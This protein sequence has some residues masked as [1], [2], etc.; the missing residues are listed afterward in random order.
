MSVSVKGITH[1]VSQITQRCPVD[2]KSIHNSFKL[3]VTCLVVPSITDSIPNVVVYIS[4]LQI[5]NHL[6]LADYAF[7]EPGDVDVLLGV[8]VFYSLLCNGQISLGRNQP[9]LQKTAFG[10]VISGPYLPNI[11]SK[12]IQCHLNTISDVHIQKQ[13][14]RFCQVEEVSHSNV[15]LSEEEKLCENIFR[16]TTYQ[17]CNG[18]FVVRLPLIDSPTRMGDSRLIAER[19]FYNLERKLERNPILKSMYIEFIRE[20]INLKHT[21]NELVENETFFHI[22]VF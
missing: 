13:L 9:V 20:Y 15:I 1:V 3:A 16:E 7:N 8:E 18:T 21:L 14:E 10:S 5:P 19:R 6:K 12:P 17:D 22:M 11:T 2:I 4:K